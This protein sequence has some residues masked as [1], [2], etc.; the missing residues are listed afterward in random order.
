MR[1]NFAQ[2]DNLANHTCLKYINIHILFQGFVVIVYENNL[3]EI[4]MTQCYMNELPQSNIISLN[5]LGANS[6]TVIDLS[7]ARIH[8]K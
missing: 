7:V 8:A 2:D 6:W 5:T 1:Y 3:S 4:K